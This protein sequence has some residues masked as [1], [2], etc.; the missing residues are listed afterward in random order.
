MWPK[1]YQQPS[2]EELTCWHD[3]TVQSWL[4]AYIKHGHWVS[5][6]VGMHSISAD[7]ARKIH[8]IEI[9]SFTEAVPGIGKGGNSTQRLTAPSTVGPSV[10][11][12]TWTNQACPNT[13]LPIHHKAR[14]QA[15]LILII[16]YQS[17]TLHNKNKT[18]QHQ[19]TDGA[20]LS[21]NP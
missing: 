2:T 1:L 18:W 17:V 11:N 21:R 19:G 10:P 20:N 7:C 4:L 5:E 16:C 13:V 3:N 14:D 8:L 15:V 9:R 6:W 12:M